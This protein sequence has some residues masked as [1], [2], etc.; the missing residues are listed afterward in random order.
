[1]SLKQIRK[2]YNVPA[3]HYGKVILKFPISNMINQEGVIVGSKGCR[4]RV[5]VL[6]DS[7]IITCHPTWNVEYEE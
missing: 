5:R 2:F 7:R 4:L 6:S 3:K 1:M